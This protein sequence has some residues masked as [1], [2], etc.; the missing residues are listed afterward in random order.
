VL[1]WRQRLSWLG[2]EPSREEVMCTCARGG[3]GETALKVGKECARISGGVE[4]K[5]S[6]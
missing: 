6:L 1:V 3:S 5:R 4:N 2:P